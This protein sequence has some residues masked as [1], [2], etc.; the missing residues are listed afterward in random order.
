MVHKEM[1]KERKMKSN[2]LSNLAIFIYVFV[3][4]TLLLVV[5]P[6]YSG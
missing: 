6:A 5:L 1:S 3:V 4:I 2:H